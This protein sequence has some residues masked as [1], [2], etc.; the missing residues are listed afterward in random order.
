MLNAKRSVTRLIAICGA[1]AMCGA[2]A[3][4]GAS[5]AAAAAAPRP[6]LS[7]AEYRQLATATAAL[8]KSASSK[9]FNWTRARAACRQ[10]GT[11]TALL[12][13]QRATCLDTVNVLDALASFPAEQRRCSAAPATSTT[14]TETTTGTTTTGST[15]TAANSAVIRVMACMDPRYQALG[16]EA[17]AIYKADLAARKQAV[18]RGFTGA[19]L[20]TLVSTPAQLRTGRSFWLAS[21][22]LAAD[23]TPLLKVTEGKEPS[24]AFNQVRIDN[25]VKQFETS[26]TAVL[27][28]HGS[29]NLSICPHQ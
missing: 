14:T 1:A 20:A 21:E 11:A 6:T 12:R 8:N 15:T 29:Q 3:I 10:V 28:E 9:S 24:S 22:K 13:T 27:A 19:C 7:S 17:K 26:A 4:F 2:A 16:R 18:S 23:V 25:D 5:A